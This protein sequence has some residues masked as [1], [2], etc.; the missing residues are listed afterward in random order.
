MRTFGYRALT[1]ALCLW[2][3]AAGDPPTTLRRGVNITNWFRYP[4]SQDPAA[5]R[6]YLGDAALAELKDSGFTFIRLPVQ[7]EL[8][9][10][11]EML[12]EAIRRAQRHGLAVVVVLFPTNWRLETDAADRAR[13]LAAWRRLA[14]L[15]RQFDPRGTFPEIMNEPVFAADPAA[16]AALQHQALL[17]IRT[18][19]P[20]H[21]VILTGADW[22]S[23]AGLRALPPETDPHVLYSFHL[24]E[25]AE[26]T[27]LGA[28]RP[29]LD[30]EAM[31]RLPFPVAD[32]AA[33]AALAQTTADPPTAALMR[34]YCQQRWDVAKVT[35][36][37]AAASAWARQHHAALLAGEFGA[38][39][40][41]NTPARLAWLGAVREA[42]EGQGIGWA[43][44]GYDDVMG[45]GL[46]PPGD[47][48]R[49]D[50]A[51]LRA[52]GVASSSPREALP[53]S[54]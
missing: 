7:P 20:H 8:L 34:F 11:Q 5:L 54:R 41:L 46:R 38:S 49:I 26:L 1:A 31:A 50:P 14:P 35:A 48:R 43:L 3:A 47:R 16:W 51:T 36:R 4:P 10:A 21:T 45:F 23:V 22:G 25:P 15:L 53:S 12:V 24:Y 39:L 2:L 30:R 37:V 33:C 52:L 44:W 6:A 17:T 27:A 18:S 42:C 28:Y 40:R 19:L 9:A 32:E 13:L 29:N